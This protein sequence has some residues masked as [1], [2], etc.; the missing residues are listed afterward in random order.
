M[1]E[2]RYR[3]INAAIETFNTDF[4]A[5]LQKVADKANVT[6]RTLH[7]YFKD[8]DELVMV[9]E[10]EMETSCK[11]AMILAIKSSNDSLVQLE[12]MLYAGVDC[13]AKYSFFYKLHQ[14]EGHNHNKKNKNCADYDYIYKRFNEIITDLQ[15]KG[16]IRMDM[17]ISWIQNLHAGIISSTVNANDDSNLGIE[18]IK[19]F[20]WESFLSGIK[21]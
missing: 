19:E 1:A 11:K 9:C 20:A 16:I 8:R 2:T 4:S 15:N 7:R 17:P 6:R 14:K 10:Q 13:G 12:N 18:K 3:I 21:K 5:P